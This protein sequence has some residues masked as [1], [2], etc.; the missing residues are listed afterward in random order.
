[1]VRVNQSYNKEQKDED[2]PIINTTLLL[3]SFLMLLLLS[4]IVVPPISISHIALANTGKSSHSRGGGR[5]NGNTDGSSSG[6]T[7][8]TLTKGGATDDNNN[9]DVAPTDTSTNRI[10]DI[11]AGVDLADIEVIPSSTRAQEI[12]L[13]IVKSAAE[14]ILW[15]FPTANA[16]I[17]Q[18]KIGVIKLAKQATKQRTVK[19]RILVPTNHLI[20][21]KVQ[22]LKEYCPNQRN[23]CQVY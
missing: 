17:C 8:D 4:L 20:E 1:M 10:R 7:S 21:Q 15:I 22:Q 9:G 11:E 13:N 12:Y 16:F 18:E 14:E 3:G 23:R 2:S 19:V 6:S 5:D